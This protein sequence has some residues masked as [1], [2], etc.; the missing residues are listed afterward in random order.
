MNPESS[1]TV[2][3]HFPFGLYVV[4]VSQ[5]GE[6]HGMTANWVTQTAFEPPM[7]AVAVENTSGTL[8]IVRDTHQ[9]AVNVLHKG[10]R[11][12]AGK[13]GKSSEQ[14]PRKLKGIKTKPA[15]GG[16]PVLAESLGWLECRLV[17]T[18]PAGDHTLILG[19][20]TD[21]GIEEQ[22]EPL[23]IQES[24]LSYSG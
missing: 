21:A 19:E 22:G 4:T 18:V 17:T 1:K 2:L 10:Q 12:L 3:R 14:V 24:G 23:T 5:D 9:F 11:D 16:T 20:V 6:E 13:L 15:A 7:I 8:E